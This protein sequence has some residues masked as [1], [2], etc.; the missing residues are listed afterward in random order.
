MIPD[1][2]L[3]NICLPDRTGK[4]PIIED[5]C[6]AIQG[7][8]IQQLGPASQCTTLEAKTVI[9]GQGQ[10]ALPGLING[11]C[12]AAMTLFRG[13]ADDLS[14]TDWL[15]N[16][17]FP[18]ESRYVQPDMVYW[19][20]KLA[21]A[22]MILSGTTTV[23]DGYFYEHQA[24]QAFADAGLRAVAAQGV[25]D[26]P[27][28]GVPDPEKKITHAA[29]FL[30]KWQNHPLVQPAVFAHSPYTCSP[31]TLVAAKELS[32]TENTL[33]FIHVAE[34]EQEKD[35]ILGRQED[36]PVCHLYKLGLLDPA[37]VCIHGIWLDE[38][39]MDILAETGAGV[40]V[41]PQ[42]NLK[43]ASGIAPLQG[44]LARNIRVGIGTDGAASNNRLDLIR[45]MDIC[46]KI[47]KVQSLDPVAVP[48]RK[49]VQMATQDGA[50][51]LG[52]GKTTGQL[53]P[54]KKADIILLNLDTAHLQPVHASE[55]PVYAAQGSDV[56]TVLINGKLVM[57]D[58]KVLSFD[59]EETLD[60]VRQLAAQVKKDQ[61]KIPA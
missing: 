56:Q 59:L 30:N 9:D 52:L 12:H 43:L 20:S 17:I 39:D 31:E 27:A 18:A 2:L 58:R 14:L 19:C 10:L 51:V 26:F 32:R 57:Q 38:Q 22:E 54:G 40:V 34:T 46:A 44:L 41:C 36:S 33:F 61:M 5:C 55:L 50:S 29:E 8:T 13:L 7:D 42:S 21:A 4:Q 45:E 6:I 48:A 35:M 60:Q 23:A 16:H 47:Q 15:H 3:T 49:V 1:I 28:P 37:T 24:A 53:A 11:H 25:I